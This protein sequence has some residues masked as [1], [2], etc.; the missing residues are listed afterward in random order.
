MSPDGQNYV[1]KEGLAKLQAELHELKTVKRKE[2]ANRIQEAKE[3][4]DLSENAEY[5]EAKNDQSFTEGRIM[6]IENMFKNVVV[7]SEEQSNG[8]VRVGSTIKVKSE[9]GERAFTI[10]GS[11]EADPV[12]GRISNESPLGEGFLGKKVGDTVEVTVP[13]GVV[14]YKILA[15]N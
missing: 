6:E 2:L 12:N 1:T 4:G 10:V 8:E 15:I 5:A 7:I 14:N 13:K 3:L 9:S 11:N